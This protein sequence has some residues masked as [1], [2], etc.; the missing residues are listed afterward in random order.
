MDFNKTIFENRKALGGPFL[1]AHRGI[2]TAN[3][4]C[5][6]LAAYKIAVEQ[7]ADVVEI[8]VTRSKD[9][10]FFVF[11][12]G[13]EPVF[14][15]CGKLIPEMTAEEVKSLPLLNQDEVPTSYHVPTL[16]EV[17][18][19]LKGKVYIN[20]DKFWT[21]VEGITAEIYKAGVEKQVIVKTYAEEKSLEEVEKFAPDLMFMSM[22]W[23]KDDVTER[24]LNRNVNFIGIEALFDRE[25]DEISTSEYIASMH[26]KGLLVWCN[27]II[28]N[29]KDV[30]SAH[31]TD[32][33]SLTDNPAKGW[34]WVADRGFDF[35]Q[36]DW[37]LSVKSYLE[38]K[39]RT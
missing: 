37:L 35:I 1:V 25:E 28:Y 32:D 31:H 9:G 2:S 8:D 3:I 4:P 26:K 11:H 7:G 38:R 12:P 24:L 6:T 29:E 23:H 13:M 21:N 10:V 14:L 36:T 19:L 22:A 39:I 34:G 20:V 5:N 33:V 16:Q 27:T 15:K 17:F 18:A 30:I